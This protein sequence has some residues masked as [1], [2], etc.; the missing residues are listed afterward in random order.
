MKR[1]T[2]MRWLGVLVLPFVGFA[3]LWWA[4]RQAADIREVFGSTFES[5]DW[6]D[7]SWLAAHH[8]R[9]WR[10]LGSRRWRGWSSDGKGHQRGTPG[11]RVDPRRRRVYYFGV[12]GTGWLPLYINTITEFLITPATVTVSSVAVGVLAVALVGGRRVSS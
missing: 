12:W 2:P 9:K 5:P 6:W 7:C 10:R 11:G 1:L 3:L 8:G 4:N